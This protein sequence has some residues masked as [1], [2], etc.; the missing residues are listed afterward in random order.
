MGH[1]AAQKDRRLDSGRSP[2]HTR[3]GRVPRFPIMEMSH[4]YPTVV[5]ALAHVCRLCCRTV[6]GPITLACRPAA[7]PREGLPKFIG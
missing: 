7:R 6:G 5:C 4:L 3:C 2:V 1:F